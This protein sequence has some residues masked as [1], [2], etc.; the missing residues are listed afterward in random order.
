MHFVSISLR[1]QWRYFAEMLVTKGEA[2]FWLD[3]T[4]FMRSR[5]LNAFPKLWHITAHVSTSPNGRVVGQTGARIPSATD[6]RCGAQLR[7]GDNLFGTLT[8]AIYLPQW[9]HF[10]HRLTDI[11]ISTRCLPPAPDDKYLYISI[12]LNSERFVF[13]PALWPH[14]YVP[15]LS[16]T[17]TVFLKQWH[18][19]LNPYSITNVKVKL[20]LY[21]INEAPYHE[22]I[23]GSGGVAPPFLTSTLDRGEWSFSHPGHFNPREKLPLPTG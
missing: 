9:P 2:I 11:S 8:P 13:L 3:S 14:G 1:V 17:T 21:L 23:W 12:H 20:S 7:L 5:S 15:D 10:F 16:V 4:Q 19:A 18:V 6:A 22:G